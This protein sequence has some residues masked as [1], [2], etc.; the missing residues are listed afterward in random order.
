VP[1]SGE[2]R[3]SLYVENG[4]QGRLQI[5]FPN[6]TTRHSV[7]LEQELRALLGAGSIRIEPRAAP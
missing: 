6:N 7:E 5:D 1:L 4:G 2:D 3:F